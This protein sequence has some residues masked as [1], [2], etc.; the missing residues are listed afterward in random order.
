MYRGVDVCARVY[1][2]TYLREKKEYVVRE[3]VKYSSR[4]EAFGEQAN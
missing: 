2:C 4:E 3:C 1:E